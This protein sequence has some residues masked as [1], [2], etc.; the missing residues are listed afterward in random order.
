M[1]QS[2]R[3]QQQLDFCLA[4]DAEKEIVRQTFLADGSRKENDSEHAWHM[5][6]MA[7]VLAEYANSDIDRF[8]VISLLL[9]HDLV[10]IYA[11]DTFAYD[12]KARENQHE[13]EVKAAEKLFGMLP[14]DQQNYFRDLWNEFEEW[15]TPESCFAHTLDNFQPMMLNRASGGVA[16]SEHKVKLSQVLR[17]NKRTGEGSETLWEYARKNFIEPSV[18][19]GFISNDVVSS[20]ISGE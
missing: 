13:R 20:K 18:K 9:V 1:I 6:V 19:Q 7:L 14:P 12:E 16:W 8:K 3:L 4:I 10:E 11:G 5:A 17:R 15:Q 2:D